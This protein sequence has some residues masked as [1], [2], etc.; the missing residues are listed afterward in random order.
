MNN[1]KKSPIDTDECIEG[2]KYVFATAFSAMTT[3]ELKEQA[4][5]IVANLNHWYKRVSE[6]MTKLLYGYGDMEKDWVQKKDTLI[7]EILDLDYQVKH[8]QWGNVRALLAIIESRR[9]AINATLA[10]NGVL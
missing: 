7:T 6:K 5:S 10:F 3:E 4:S 2:L 1:P 9:V 8:A